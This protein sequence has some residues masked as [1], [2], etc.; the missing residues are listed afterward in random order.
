MTRLADMPAGTII[1]RSTYGNYLMRLP[2]QA[3]P[4]KAFY[5]L[6]VQNDD[7]RYQYAQIEVT[8]NAV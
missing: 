5:T 3:E 1:H 7:G 4:L 8:A 2:R 6:L